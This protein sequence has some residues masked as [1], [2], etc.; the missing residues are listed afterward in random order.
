MSIE[1][2]LLNILRECI[3]DDSY[4]LEKDETLDNIID[5]LTMINF[6]VKIESE[7]NIEID[8]EDLIGESFTTYENIV[9]YIESRI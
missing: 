5:S 1:D 2:R 6:I 7:F 9:R 3:N 8:D 4:T